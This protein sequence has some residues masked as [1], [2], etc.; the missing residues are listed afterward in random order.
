[1]DCCSGMTIGALIG[2]L[3]VVI[4]VVTTIRLLWRGRL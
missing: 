2:M 3:V 1:M 4:L